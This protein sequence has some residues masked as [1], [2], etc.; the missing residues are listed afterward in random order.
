MRSDDR[1]DTRTFGPASPP[2]PPPS[3]RSFLQRHSRSLAAQWLVVSLL[4]SFGEARAADEASLVQLAQVS[5]PVEDYEYAEDDYEYAEDD[6]EAEQQEEA[7]DEPPHDMDGDYSDVEEITVTGSSGQLIATDEAESAVQFSAQDLE[8]LGATDISDIAKVTPNLEIT[9]AGATTANFFIRGVGLADY[10]ANS[11]SAVAI[12]Q[13]GVPLNASTLQLVGLFD[14]V[15]VAVLRGPQ[16]AG[17]GRNASAGAIKIVSRKPTGELQAQLRTSLGAYASGDALNAFFQSYEGALELP[18]VD[19]LLSTRIAF[20]VDD[21]DPYMTNGCGNAPPFNARTPRTGLNRFATICGEQVPQTVPASVSPIPVGLP[22][23]V[24][25]KSSWAAR[26]LF[27]F[28]PNLLDMDWLLNVHGSQLDQQSTLG[29]AMGTSPTLGRGTS[30]GYFEPDQLEELQALLRLGLSQS[31]AQAVLADNLASGRPLD[32]RPFRGDYNRVGQ[33]TRDTWGASLNGEMFIDDVPV[34]GSFTLQS[35]TGYDGYDRFRDTDQDFTPEVLFESIQQDSAWQLFQELKAKG[36]MNA[37]LFRWELGGYFLMEDLQ[38]DIEQKTV[39]A[40]FD[41]DRSF[42]QSLRSFAF[43]GGLGWDFLENFTLDAGVRYNW[44]RKRF[45]FVQLTGNA[46]FQAATPQEQTWTAPTGLISLTY[47]FTEELSGYWKYSRGWK[48]GHFNANRP[49]V[50]PAEPE[51]LDAVEAGF[52]GNF[53]DARLSLSGSIFYYKYKNYQVFLF[54]NAVAS[55][56]ILEIINANDA[57]QY[58]AEFELRALPLQGWSSIPEIWGDLSATIRFGWLESQFLDFVNLVEVNRNNQIIQQVVNYT[59]NRLPNAPEFK[60]SGAIEWPFEF[61]RFGML[62]PRYD[63]AWSDDIFF[64]PNEGRGTLNV[65][66][67]LKPPYTTGQR[68]YTLHNLRLAWRNEDNTLEVAAWVRNLTDERYK[69]F[70]FD[71]SI[72]AAVVINFVGEPRTAGVDLSF[73]F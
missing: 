21:A 32:I 8:A 54:E 69:T 18:L 64:D 53:F 28:E 39:Q 38:S 70:A 56:P 47:R 59:G 35:I 36:E 24:G 5:D 61:G 46:S 19:D 73:R 68:A 51:T 31:L 22:R 63:F 50:L 23:D 60:V 15:S 16:G 65:L 9:T 6:E 33:T 17:S 4:A 25:D 55:P 43:Y 10:S 41:F 14:T 37:G 62:A 40:T 72:F 57:E 7:P 66:D 20:R 45:N 71:A 52:S 29:Q 42:D 44:E 49:N 48:G 13:D 3:R 26:A 58:G 67:Q 11:A 30:K 2:H 27:R 12:Y 34:L 1:S